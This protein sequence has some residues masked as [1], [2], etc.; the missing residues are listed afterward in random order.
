[1]HKDFTA[2]GIRRE[3][4]AILAENGITKPT[5]I[6]AQAIP[7]IMSGKDVVGQS[8]TG[9][10]KTLAFI[11][12]ILEKIEISKPIVQ[13]LIITPTRELALQITREVAKLADQLGIQV[14]SVYGGQDVD[15]QIKKLK[16]G[17]QIVIGT[18]GRLMDHLRRGTIQLENVTKLVLDEADQMLHMGFLEDVE[19]LVRQ[20]SNKRQ[21][22]LFSATMPSKIRGLAD[23]YM[24]KPLDIRIQTKNI[25]LDEIKQIMVEVPE[26]EKIVKLSSM[27][28]EYR[29]YLAIV[30]CH[31]K[32]RAIA[33]NMALSQKGYETDELHGELSQ[34]KREQVMKRFREAK[35]Q[36]LVATDIAA[37]GLDVEGVTHI[38]NYD[39]PHDVDSYIHRIGRTGRAGQ[40]GM[41][42]TLID[43]HEQPYVRL[44]E[45]GIRAAIEKHKVNDQKVVSTDKRRLFKAKVEEGKTA[46]EKKEKKRAF[47]FGKTDKKKTGNHSGA[48]SRSR[49]K[50][51]ENEKGEQ[52]AQPGREKRK[53]R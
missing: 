11:L 53:N 22:M 12:P 1:M 14:L 23:R 45:Q 16:G 44:I 26:S 7:A 39:I 33:V 30:F 32:K 36:I 28:D 10:G 3:I 38:F 15:R 4:G 50:P 37:R 19:E 13:A 51:K 31:T 20:T 27:I 5:E 9:T 48:N 52:Q 42:I 17:A 49:R 25:T 2:L 8:Q 47:V 29:P 41:A 18:P 40:A 35:I 46:V 43:P 21:T 34:P 6:Q 24:R